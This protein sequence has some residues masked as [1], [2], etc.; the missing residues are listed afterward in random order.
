MMIIMAIALMRKWQSHH[1]QNK[2]SRQYKRQM[3]KTK[4]VKMMTPNQ[5]M[6]I[7]KTNLVMNHLRMKMIMMTSTRVLHFCTMT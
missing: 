4:K 2:M 1:T 7:I 6:E 5:K 3:K